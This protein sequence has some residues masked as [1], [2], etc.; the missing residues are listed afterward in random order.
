MLAVMCQIVRIATLAVIG[1]MRMGEAVKR[2]RAMAE[3]KYGRGH[4]KA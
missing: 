4:H 1:K 3:G 2:V